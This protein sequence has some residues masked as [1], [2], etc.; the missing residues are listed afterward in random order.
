MMKRTLKKNT[1]QSLFSRNFIWLF[2]FVAVGIFFAGLGVKEHSYTAS[3]SN[4]SYKIVAHAPS[5]QENRDSNHDKIDKIIFPV[6][7]L[8]NC[9]NQNECKDFCKKQENMLVCVNFAEKQGLMSKAD[10]IKGRKMAELGASKGPGGCDS[11]SSCDAFC[12]NVKNIRECVAFGRKNNMI[13]KAELAEAEKVIAALDKGAKLPGGCTSKASC[14]TYCQQPKNIQQCVDF[15]E[16]A[17]FM[18]AKEAAMVR[19]TGGVGPGGC[20][21]KDACEVFCAQGGNMAEC[22]EFATK[23]DL[24]PAGEK[25]EAMKVL[26]ALKKGV[27]L[28]GGCAG[29]AACEAFCRKPENMKE[30][31]AFAEA[32]GFIPPE[33]AK[34]IRKMMEKGITSGPGGCMSN[35]SCEA[36]CKQ[37]TKM[38]E[39]LAFMK[40]AGINPEDMPR[41]SGMKIEDHRQ[42]SDFEE[43]DE[44][45]EEFEEFEEEDFNEDEYDEF[46][47]IDEG[48]EFEEDF[49]EEF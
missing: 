13:P 31:F 45:E 32:A 18:N 46:E 29:K 11:A 19:K 40:K 4:G 17:G 1:R 22:L 36:Y 47:E 10:A 48:D 14:D 39:C 8:G 30:C 27:K 9:R 42:R 21:G 12:S 20:F 33:E 41:N 5:G 43:F 6:K 24:M 16:A 35:E 49:E 26:A 34:F 23:H 15:A 37:P 28:P 44:E 2:I 25:E 3:I 7:E 38:L